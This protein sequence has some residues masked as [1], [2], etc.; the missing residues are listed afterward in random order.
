MMRSIPLGITVFVLAASVVTI[1]DTRSQVTP[2]SKF[3]PPQAPD[4]ASGNANVD[5][6][7]VD[8]LGASLEGVSVKL[9]GLVTREAM[10]NDVGFATFAALPE[11]R[12]DVV[13]S[14]KGLEPSVP[15]VVD[16]P[17]SGVTS[18]S[19]VLKPYGPTVRVTNACGGFDPGS[20][21]TLSA[22]AHLVLH[23]KVIDQRTIE[24][25]PAAAD[26]SGDLTTVNRVQVLESF[27]RSLR[28][29][30]TGAIVEIRQGG[31][32]IDRG[33]FIDV[34]TFNQFAPLNV[35]DE[36]VL[37]IYIDSAGTYYV[38][39]SEEGAFRVRNGAVDPLGRGGAAKAWQG[40]HAQE[41]FLALRAPI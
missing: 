22:G 27:M 7:I 16:L 19:L 18:V 1:A 17:A 23:V 12:Y 24:A 13:A 26:A 20:I 32:R 15:R 34:H 11:G 21:R 41:F 3:T 38:H 8:D 4:I 6:L 25:V 40:H 9:T 10:S 14:K 31:G 39:G 33:H 36:Y 2:A 5:V 28:A 30:M 37:F 29:P 35:G